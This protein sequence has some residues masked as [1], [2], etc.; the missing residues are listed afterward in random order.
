VIEPGLRATRK[1]Q[2]RQALLDAALVLLEQ[3]SLSSL[4][5][6][7]VPGPPGSRRPRSTGTSRTP[8]NSASRWCTKR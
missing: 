1:L 3:Q 2:T 6:R 4:G 8:A 5:L 7:E